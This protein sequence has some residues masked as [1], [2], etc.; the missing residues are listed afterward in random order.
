MVPSDL[1]EDFFR[2]RGDMLEVAHI[3]ASAFHR[4][5][6]PGAG[7]LSWA[8]R[9]GSPVLNAQNRERRT[10]ASNPPGP[11]IGTLHR[12]GEFSGYSTGIGA[13]TATLFIAK[14]SEVWAI[15]DAMMRLNASIRRFI[16][17]MMSDDMSVMRPTALSRSV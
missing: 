17:P 12:L 10:L 15:Y 7:R 14:R 11:G 4:A 1:F 9:R 6:L 8:E 13:A 3:R 16:R 5:P 2:G